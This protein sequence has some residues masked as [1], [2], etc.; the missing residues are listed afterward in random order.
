VQARARPELKL[1]P[2]GENRAAK[3][4]VV[5]GHGTEEIALN[6]VHANRAREP[7]R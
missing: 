1:A 4:V 2:W 5:D 7:R 3:L 6:H